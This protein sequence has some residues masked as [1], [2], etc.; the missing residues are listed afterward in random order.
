MKKT[1]TFIF[2][3]FYFTIIFGQ[4]I[5]GD[6]GRL[7][8][9]KYFHTINSD[10]FPD[11]ISNKNEITGKISQYRESYYS[12]ELEIIFRPSDSIL[13]RNRKY[14][15]K[16]YNGELHKGKKVG[17]WEYNER[18]GHTSLTKFIEYRNDTITETEFLSGREISYVNDSSIIF[19]R[20]NIFKYDNIYLRLV[21]NF[22]CSKETDCIYKLSNDKIIT[23]STFEELQTTIK[24]IEIGEFNRKIKELMQ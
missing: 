7:D 10:T 13:R 15:D 18:N 19:G 12:H 6:F 16:L 1:L 9:I 11:I 22:N 3:I 17:N 23:R 8:S 4:H 5:C 21:V 2:F 24:R 14:I 20:I